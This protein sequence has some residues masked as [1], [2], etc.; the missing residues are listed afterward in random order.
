M[1][2]STDQNTS[3]D[4]TLNELVFCYQYCTFAKSQPS[5]SPHA[6]LV[7]AFL[8]QHPLPRDVDY[9][10]EWLKDGARRQEAGGR[11]LQLVEHLPL[12]PK[13]KEPFLW[14]TA[15]HAAW[16]LAVGFASHQ[17]LKRLGVNAAPSGLATRDLDS[18]YDVVLYH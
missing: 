13:T 11:F 16:Y 7:D 6:E 12:P 1:S 18:S 14:R 4:L 17:L 15:K 8:Q 10:I 3:S 5:P 9:P 2:T